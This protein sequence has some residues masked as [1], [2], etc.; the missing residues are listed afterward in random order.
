MARG[1]DGRSPE[2]AAG[3]LSAIKNMP[4]DK[5]GIFPRWRCAYRGDEITN[6]RTRLFRFRERH[7]QLQNRNIPVFLF[8]LHRHHLRVNLHVLTDHFQD[9]LAQLRRVVRLGVATTT[10]RNDNLQTFF[11]DV[12]G[13]LFPREKKSSNAITYPPNRRLR[14][15][16]FSSSMKRKGRS[17]PSRRSTVSA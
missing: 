3:R 5:P 7:V 15:P 1:I 12:G 16:F 11:C 4:G 9:V 10:L 14:K 8:Q 2:Y 6:L 17:S 13:V